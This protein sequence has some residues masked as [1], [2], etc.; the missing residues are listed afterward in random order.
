MLKKIL[1]LD[2]GPNETGFVLIWREGGIISKGVKP[3]DFILNLIDS[4]DQSETMIAVET[5]SSY[6]KMVGNDIFDT[7]IWVGRFIQSANYPEEVSKVSRRDVKL[8][9][10]GTTRA[11]D[12][13]IRAA[14]IERC[15]EPGTKKNPGPTHGIA[16]HAWAALAVALTVKD[17]LDET[18]KA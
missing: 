9:I 12:K 15:G 18:S 10:C 6:G 17:T 5:I 3:N 8:H 4:T 11:K 7:C 2:P 14:L 13:D 1:A 16:S